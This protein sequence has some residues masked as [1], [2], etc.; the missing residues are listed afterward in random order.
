MSRYRSH[1]A[2]HSGAWIAVAVILFLVAM[3]MRWLAPDVD[4]VPWVGGV[5]A[6][7]PVL[8]TVL[9]IFVCIGLAVVHVREKRRTNHRMENG[10]CAYCG[11]DLRGTEADQCPECGRLVWRPRDPVTGQI[12]RPRSRS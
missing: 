9:T 3:V 11:Y 1:F 8:I 2:A 6:L 4:P 7:S 5:I 12:M 10:L